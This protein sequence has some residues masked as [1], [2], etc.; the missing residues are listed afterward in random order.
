MKKLIL[1]LALGIATVSQAQ[2]ATP[3]PTNQSAKPKP[4]PEQIASRQSTRMQKT[5]ALTEDQKQKTYQ[6]VLARAT[7]V[8]A[9]KSKYGPDA[10]K[11]AMHSEM[12]PVHEQF[13]QTMNGILTPDQKT[14]W[15]A[16]RA[17]MKEKRG[18]NKTEAGNTA[19]EENSDSKK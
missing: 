1:M 12:K 10:D 13:L 16:E 18:K 6:A 8:Q 4:N 7:S 17:K 2:Q 3:S 11:K 19:P 15:D 5:L 9:I 14:K